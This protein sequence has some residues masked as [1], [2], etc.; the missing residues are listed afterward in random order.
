MV[1]AVGVKTAGLELTP[2]GLTF[3][4][5]GEAATFMTIAA[6]VAAIVADDVSQLVGIY[7][8]D[9]E[10][11]VECKAQ[12]DAYRRFQAR[13]AVSIQDTIMN[14]AEVVSATSIGGV[15]PWSL[16]EWAGAGLKLIEPLPTD[17][18]GSIVRR[19]RAF[20]ELAL[21]GGAEEVASTCGL[22]LAELRRGSSPLYG[23]PAPTALTRMPRR[24]NF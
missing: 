1:G 20:Q 11:A 7:E 9:D 15:S 12:L 23:T 6:G 3:V 13:N 18:L 24:G 17:T 5:K 10:N 19:I 2:D 16:D 22:I 21:A 8:D 4:G 14:C